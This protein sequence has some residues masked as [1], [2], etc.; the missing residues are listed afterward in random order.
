MSIELWAVGLFGLVV[1]SFL[2]VCIYRLPR[3]ESVVLPRSRCPH[4]QSAVKAWQ[5]FPL[6]SYLLLAGRCAVCR[7]RISPFYPL[8]ELL[9]AG[10]FLLFFLKFGFSPA[11][12]VNL[13]LGCILII[14]IFIDLF[15]RILPNVITLPGIAL[16]ILLS[17]LQSREFLDGSGVQFISQGFWLQAVLGSLLGV[18]LGGGVLWLVAALY[19]KWRKFEGMGFG[20]IKMMAM[21]GAFLGWKYAWLT[22]FTGSLLGALV[23]S[24][25]ILVSKRG[26]RYE[27][28]FGTF[29][30]LGAILVIMKGP[31]FVS[32]YFDLMS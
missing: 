26:A 31:Q 3:G 19:L 32:W 21:V 1:G 27:L 12:L 18:A 22:I 2:N 7:K 6:L 24:A 25:Y 11:F 10:M 29:L 9:T 28:P 5:N 30:G 20:D 14:L 16:G 4:C 13:L 8:L 23:G 15:Q 17:P